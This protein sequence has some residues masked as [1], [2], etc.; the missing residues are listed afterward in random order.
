MSKQNHNAHEKIEKNI[1]LMAILIAVAVSFGGLLALTGMLLMA[2][3]VVKTLRA[4]NAVTAPQP[5]LPPHASEA[6]A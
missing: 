6:R 3:N 4:A 1:G 2:W 5:V